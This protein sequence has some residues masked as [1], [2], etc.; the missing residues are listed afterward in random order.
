MLRPKIAKNVTASVSLGKNNLPGVQVISF[1]YCF[2]LT[3]YLT[4][5]AWGLEGKNSLE[6]HPT[7]NPTMTQRTRNTKQYT[8]NI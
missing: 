1:V 6:P 4:H 8:N 7:D 5:L 2:V 3:I